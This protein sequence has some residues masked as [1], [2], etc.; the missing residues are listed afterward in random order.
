M[1]A[2]LFNVYPFFFRVPFKNQVHHSI[3]GLI[4]QYALKSGVKYDRYTGL[5]IRKNGNQFSKNLPRTLTP[6]FAVKLWKKAWKRVWKRQG[7]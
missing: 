1:D 2:M 4:L 3:Y 5:E 7:E 6:I